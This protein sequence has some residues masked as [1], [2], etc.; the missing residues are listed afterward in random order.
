MRQDWWKY[1]L[2]ALLPVVLYVGFGVYQQIQV[3]VTA[4]RILGHYIRTG[5]LPPLPQAPVVE[6]VPEVEE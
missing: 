1:V 6:E 2:S 5:V 3:G 4:N